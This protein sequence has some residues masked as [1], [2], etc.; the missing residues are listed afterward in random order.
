MPADDVLAQMLAEETN[1]A[2]RN[3]H[4]VQGAGSLASLSKMVEP[5][6]RKPVQAVSMP[7]ISAGARS[8]LPLPSAVVRRN[9][10]ASE[11]A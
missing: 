7:V 3:R 10:L 5:T 1:Y 9:L 11:A 4:R 6:K 2:N 8:C